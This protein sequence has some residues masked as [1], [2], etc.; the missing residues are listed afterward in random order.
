[1][2]GNNVLLVQNLLSGNWGFPKGHR[3][4]QDITW[5][6]TAVREV[7]EETGLRENIHYFICSNQPDLWGR[8][9]YWTATALRIGPLRR[10]VSE[11]RAIEW[12]P[13]KNL[14]R[15]QKNYDLTDWFEK[16]SPIKCEAV[17]LLN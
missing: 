13:V 17:R 8:R 14:K 5:R 3:E 7:E 15:Y 12:V 16:E 6:D 11:H 10:N 9:P 1:M 2:N 4:L